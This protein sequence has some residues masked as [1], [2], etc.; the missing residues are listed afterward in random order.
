MPLRSVRPQGVLFVP[1]TRKGCH[2]ILFPQVRSVVAP[3]AG[4]RSSVFGSVSF[5]LNSLFHSSTS[6]SAISRVTFSTNSLLTWSTGPVPHEPRPS[7]VIQVCLP[8]P[9]VSP[10]FIP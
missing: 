5:V 10:H 1:G 8:P 2:Y 9:P 4:A 6:V 7:A 3:L